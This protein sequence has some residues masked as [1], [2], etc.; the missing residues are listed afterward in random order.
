M[1]W[2]EI[3]EAQ[4]EDPEEPEVVATQQEAPKVPEVEDEQVT[5]RLVEF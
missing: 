5:Y 1:A 3:G 4:Q 2:P